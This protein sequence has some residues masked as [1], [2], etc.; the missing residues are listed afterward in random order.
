M[1]IIPA[2]A[3]LCPYCTFAIAHWPSQRPVQLCGHCLRPL[4]LW[5]IRIWPERIFKISELLNASRHVAAGVAFAG[6]TACATGLLSNKAAAICVSCAFALL[7]LADFADVWLGL[8]SDVVRFK[9]T[10]CRGPRARL[11]AA[12]NLVRG[13]S[14]F[15]FAY[16]GILLAKGLLR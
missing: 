16:G 11:A 4:L 1:H 10:I 6:L 13:I 8:R 9:G 3:I 5:P 2:P 15:C 7:G 12:A 14:L